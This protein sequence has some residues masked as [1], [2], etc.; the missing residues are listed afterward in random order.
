MENNSNDAAA[1]PSDTFSSLENVRAVFKTLPIPLARDGVILGRDAP[2]TLKA[3][4]ETLRATTKEPFVEIGVS[5]DVVG[6]LL[7]REALLRRLK[8]EQVVEFVLKRVKPYMAP[9]EILQLSLDIEV[10]IDGKFSG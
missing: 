1:P 7:V 9:R 5:D 2:L 3:V 8:P 6:C 10:Q 4:Q